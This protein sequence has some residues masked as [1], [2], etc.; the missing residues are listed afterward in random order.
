MSNININEFIF[1]MK[2][3]IQEFETFWK[4]Q[5]ELDP[6]NY[7]LEMMSGNWDEQFDLHKEQ[8]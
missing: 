1:S 8:Q 2:I 7:P 3:A 6:D 4:S 5:N